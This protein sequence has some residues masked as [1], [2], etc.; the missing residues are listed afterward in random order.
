M[1]ALVKTILGLSSVVWVATLAV[2]GGVCLVLWVLM[3]RRRRGDGLEVPRDTE[4]ALRDNGEGVSSRLHQK[5]FEAGY[6]GPHATGIFA[7]AKLGLALA[8]PAALL[9]ANYVLGWDLRQPMVI[10][11]GLGFAGFLGPNIWLQSRISGRQKAISRTLPDAMDLLVTCVEAGLGIDQALA[12]VVQEM[13]IA[14]PVLAEELK[15]TFLEINAGI[16]RTVAFRRLAQRTGVEDLRSLAAT[17]AQTEMF[18]TSVA[19]GLRVRAE[20]LRTRRM[21]IAEEKAAMISVKMA[22]PLVLCI[23]PSLVAIIIGP[24]VVR[25]FKTMLPGMGN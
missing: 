3:A 25:I 18:G 23:L 8:G 6:R 22:I 17:L 24:A 10:A 21:Q 2:T 9:G 5:L 15:L 12:R 19:A 16:S 11:A 20:W 13:R 14:A 4:I 1:Q 7:S